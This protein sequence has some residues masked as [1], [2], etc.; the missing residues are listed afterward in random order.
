MGR[1]NETIE[2]QAQ[3]M[4]LEP[5]VMFVSRDQ[6]WNLYVA[7]RFEEAEAEYQRSQTLDAATPTP[8][9]WPCCAL[10]RAGPRS[11]ALRKLF[12]GIWSGQPT[13]A[14]GA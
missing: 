3:V 6:Q 10:W 2:L 4:A 7:G 14:V 5:R 13:A 8:I 12:Q 1:I 11:Q 9:S